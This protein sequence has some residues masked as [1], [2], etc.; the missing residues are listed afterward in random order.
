MRPF[1]YERPETIDEVF[2]LL[3]RA[4]PATSKL[5][6]GGTDLLPSMKD[7]ILAP[8][9][10]ID[11]K[12]LTE[13]DDQI[14][15]TADGLRIGALATLAEI[16]NN[17]F[18]RSD[19]A[20]L[21]EAAGLAASPQLRNMATIGGNL[22]QRP[23]CWY[24]RDHEVH[25]WL[26]GGEECFAVEGENQQHAI[27]GVSPCHAAHP[28]DLAAALLMFG[29]GV[30]ARGATHERTIAIEGFFTPPTADHRLEHTLRPDE[31]I[32]AITLPSRPST[33]HSV[34]LKAM[35]RAAW[36]FA[37]IGVAALLDVQEGRIA[38]ARLVLNGV[39]PIPWR[40]AKADSLLLNST[41]GPLIFSDAARLALDG[42]EP[43]SENGYKL[44]LAEALILRA[45]AAVAAPPAT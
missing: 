18:V 28:S 39:A 5:L 29:A 40:A 36:A 25:C 31:V 7:E 34:Y 23:R 27:F 13:I 17:P 38:E 33:A 14:E 43:L 4:A 41:P 45:L 10:L 26:K 12:R 19:Y 2:A 6:A 37:L 24:F 44:P 32:V 8:N 22:L 9:E 20:A 16:E 30:V 3:G 15:V 1:L 11:I 42:A 21:A 35:D